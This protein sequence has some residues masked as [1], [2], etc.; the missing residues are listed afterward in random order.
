VFDCL[1]GVVAARGLMFVVCGLV[2]DCL[3]FDSAFTQRS[4][5]SAVKKLEIMLFGVAAA[6]V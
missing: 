3:V 4:P 1:F 6:R 5:F 2:F